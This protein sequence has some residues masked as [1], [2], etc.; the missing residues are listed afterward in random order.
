MQIAEET[1]LDSRDRQARK[2]F[3]MLKEDIKPVRVELVN[4]GGNE[5]REAYKTQIMGH[6]IRWLEMLDLFYVQWE[7][8]EN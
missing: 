4:K 3:G 8:M 5:V 6:V 2:P 7:D 1:I